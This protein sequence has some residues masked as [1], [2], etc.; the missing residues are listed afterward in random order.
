MVSQG[1]DKGMEDKVKKKKNTSLT[2]TTKHKG[3]I[4]DRIFVF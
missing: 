2:E 4:M 3:L 1:V